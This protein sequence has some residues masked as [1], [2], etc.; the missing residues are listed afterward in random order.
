M[1]SE[2]L[3]KMAKDGRLT[4]RVTRSMGKASL[5]TKMGKNPKYIS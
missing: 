4:G 1:V 5:S 2:Y 3:W